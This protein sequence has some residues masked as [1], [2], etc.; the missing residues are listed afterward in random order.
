MRKSLLLATKG[1]SKL[2]N[3]NQV[4]PAAWPPRLL[5]VLLL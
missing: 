5:N 4:S 1:S 2:Q 3:K